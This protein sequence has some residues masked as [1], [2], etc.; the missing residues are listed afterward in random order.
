[1]TVGAPQPATPLRSASQSTNTR[2]AFRQCQV[3]RWI[4]TL[5]EKSTPKPILLLIPQAP[6]LMPSFVIGGYVSRHGI[7]LAS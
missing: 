1:M 6:K 3:A 2:E 5:W 4:S 7:N